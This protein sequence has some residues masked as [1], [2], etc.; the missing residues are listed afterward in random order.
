MASI[1]T[2][3]HN[4]PRVSSPWGT[5][6][7]ST[8][9]ETASLGRHISRQTANAHGAPASPGTLTQAGLARL[10]AEPQEGPIEY[11]LHLLLR[12]RRKFISS[13]TGS[14][15][16]GSQHSKAYMTSSAGSGTR[17]DANTFSTRPSMAPT[18][19]SRQARLQQLTTQ[20][21]W[22]LQQSSP[23]HSSST[24][25]LVLP[26]LPEATPRLHAP[27]GTAKL[28]PG[29]EESQGALYEI[30]VSDDGSFV[31]LVEAELEE[32]LTNLKAMAAS[33]GC[34][35]EVL[36]KV[37]VGNCEWA[38]I[39]IEDVK[40]EEKELK[41]Y[42]E[43]LWVAE[44][45]VRPD[46]ESTTQLPNIASVLNLNDQTTSSSVRKEEAELT[47]SKTEQLRISLTGASASGKSTLLGTLSTSTLDNGRGKSRLS[48][49]KHRHEIASGITSSV[50]QELIGYHA[51]NAYHE[52]ALQQSTEVFNYASENISSWNDV[53]CYADRLAF[54]SDS[55]G[56]PRYSKSAIRTLTSWKP[57]WSFVCVAANDEEEHTRNHDAVA[58]ADPTTLTEP[59]GSAV[60]LAVSHLEL[61]LRLG[62]PMVVL[63]TKL[64]VATKS[65]LRQTLA[66][67]LSTLKTKGRK[68][69]MLSTTSGLLSGPADAEEFGTRMLRICAAD[70][71]DV[72]RVLA[73]VKQDIDS[74]V[75][76]LLT[77]AVT[78]NGIAKVHA[79]LRSLPLPQ[80][81]TS[82]DL[83]FRPGHR[84][85]G[86]ML[87]S[88]TVF[89][90]DEVFAMPPSKVYSPSTQYAADKGVVL[91]GRIA[92]GSICVGDELIFG[93]FVHDTDPGRDAHG[94][95]AMSSSA[96]S[97]PAD[98][99]KVS[100]KLDV[101]FISVR[102]VSIRNLR[103]PVRSLIHDQVGTIGVEHLHEGNELPSLRRA[104]R[105]MV[106]LTPSIDKDDV[107]RRK[108]LVA[109]QRHNKPRQ[110]RLH[111]TTFGLIC[112]A[113]TASFTSADFGVS[114]SPSLI[115]GGHAIVYIN[116]VRAAVK[117][118]AVALVDDGTDGSDDSSSPTDMFCFDDNDHEYNG[119]TT[120]RDSGGY[121]GKI[122]ITFRFVSSVEWM[123][124]DDPV[125]VVP[126]MAAAGPIS[127]P[128]TAPATGLA[129]FVGRVL[130][131]N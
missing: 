97:A 32:S 55:P 81:F 10:E 16:S 109:I 37:V 121:E 33:L 78:G 86:P 36:R 12:K 15:I 64:D 17:G 47:K 126:T 73:V 46:L 30:G 95:S 49:L 119:A 130:G 18:S 104:R 8:P 76:I 24:A 98:S 28:L 112:H 84:M 94:E 100:Q 45:L 1:F 82:P 68:P 38:D 75:P 35:V 122:K 96:P 40:A 21:L 29:L 31:G 118:N 59:T 26:I 89:H 117:V 99:I 3:D 20:L 79:L 106:L 127:G 116:S 90:V 128:S 11:K 125:L 69:I 41:T 74:V 111:D 6:G 107:E 2:Y 62:L 65:G 19:L 103:L 7:S 57:H 13:S 77:S 131:K 129:G 110:G 113:F 101:I 87:S 83:G 54:L 23:F 92:S 56:L 9:Q 105:G 42:K 120:S 71:Q 53:H 88:R 60:D 67:V 5:P 80:A 85:S 39:F 51:G 43:N 14:Q 52:E 27:A 66:K 108:D 102:I 22:R 50:A 61:C 124:V 25:N 93:P 72:Q 115:L 44:A 91:C 70:E 114:M 58:P 34:V 63:I 48:L 123:Q 4:P